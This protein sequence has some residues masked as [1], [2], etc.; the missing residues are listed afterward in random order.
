M[1]QLLKSNLGCSSQVRSTTATYRVIT[2]FNSKFDSRSIAYISS[3]FL[4]IWLCNT[5]LALITTNA[6]TGLRG[7]ASLRSSGFDDASFHETMLRVTT[8]VHNFITLSSLHYLVKALFPS[9]HIQYFTR[10]I[11]ASDASL[12]D[13][14][15]DRHMSL[16]VQNIVESLDSLFKHTHVREEYSKPSPQNL[17]IYYIFSKCSN[18]HEKKKLSYVQNLLLS[19]KILLYVCS[20]LIHSNSIKLVQSN[21]ISIISVH[22]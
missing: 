3:I 10:R 9:K 21:I 16:G 5:C 12:I 13:S 7:V 11:F 1:E 6:T 15:I 2:R 8:V 18:L 14:C 19:L 17:G 22:I 20:E 4:A